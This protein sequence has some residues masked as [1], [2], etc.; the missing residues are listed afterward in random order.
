MRKHKVL[1]LR[2]V[3]LQPTK[4]CRFFQPA[5]PYQ[6]PGGQYRGVMFE[7]F[8]QSEAKSVQMFIYCMYICTYVGSKKLRKIDRFFL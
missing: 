6:W 7:N 5:A 3:H 1:T 4:G 8:I 2:T